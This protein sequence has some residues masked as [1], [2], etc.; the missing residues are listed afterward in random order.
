MC[1]LWCF[2]SGKLVRTARK[3]PLWVMTTDDAS[4]DAEQKLLAEGAFV[5][6]TPAKN[7]RL[8][9]E[10]S[11]RRLGERGITRVL[12]EGGPILSAFLVRSDLVDEAV[13]VQSSRVLGSDAIDALEGLRLEALTQS[14][15]LEMV[16]RRMSGADSLT[17]YFRR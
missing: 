12:V 8:D 5:L 9:L 6:R 3:V 7:G 13:I 1:S 15:H 2:Y 14:P 10:A 4:A 16:E 11:L 17:R